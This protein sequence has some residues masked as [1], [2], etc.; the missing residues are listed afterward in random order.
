MALRGT[1]HNRAVA[2]TLAQM[3]CMKRTSNLRAA[4]SNALV[5]LRAQYNH[6][7][8]VASEECLSAATFVSWR[9]KDPYINELL[10]RYFDVAA[11]LAEQCWRYVTVGMHGNCGY[12]P[13]WVTKLFVRPWRTPVNPSFSNRAMTSRGFRTGLNS[14]LSDADCLC[15]DEL[16]IRVEGLRLGGASRSLH[17]G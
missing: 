8:E 9:C 15:S 5:Q 14:P 6:W 3:R 13:I 10:D 11:N 16:G 7:D 2:R 17:G 4:P 1:T 12:A